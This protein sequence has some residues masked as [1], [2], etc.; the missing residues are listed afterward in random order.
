M[1]IPFDRVVTNLKYHKY[2]GKIS[3][4]D[5][6]NLG[7]RLFDDI[8]FADQ[9]GVTREFLKQI[10]LIVITEQCGWNLPREPKPEEL[11]AVKD[12][13][14]TKYNTDQKRFNGWKKTNIA[15]GD[16]P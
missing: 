14:E 12:I 7:L 11:I 5:Y 8:K 10:G 1:K 15:S 3:G 9:L 6:S 13:I 16:L 4:A 2:L